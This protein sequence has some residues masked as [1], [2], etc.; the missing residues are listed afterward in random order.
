MSDAFFFDIRVDGCD[1][2]YRDEFAFECDAQK[3]S[4]I[5]FEFPSRAHSTAHVKGKY[6]QSDRAFQL[7]P[8][9]DVPARV[10]G[11]SVC[12]ARYFRDF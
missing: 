4:H 7:F 9:I 8:I 3:L 2:S 10:A 1:A 6:S 5:H 12:Y 11:Q